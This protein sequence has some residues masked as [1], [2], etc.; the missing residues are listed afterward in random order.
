MAS[1]DHEPA[2][3]LVTGV[4]G[5]SGVGVMRAVMGPGVRIIAGDLDAY[6]AGLYLVPEPQRRLLYR[7]DDP[8]FVDHILEICKADGVDVVVPTVDSELVPLARAR[9]GFDELGVRLVLAHLETLETCLDKWT[10]VRRVGDVVRVPATTLADGDAA[11]EEIPLPVIV[12]PRSGSGSRGIRLIRERDELLRVERDGSQ[13]VQEYLPGAEFSVDV[14]TAFD[15]RVVGVVPRERLKI[16]SGIA[17]T[18]RAVH[19]GGLESSAAAVAEAIGLVGVANVQLKRADDGEPALLEVNPR[20]PGTMPL[21]IA[22]GVNMPKL[23]VGEA[24]G[25][26]MPAG[27]VQFRETAMVRYLEDQCFPVEELERAERA[28]VG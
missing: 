22:A 7:G 23:A 26:P 12:K 21:T 11:L 25:T 2:T 10:L 19:D 4:G 8:A 18:A 13:L 5:P 6:A 27:R 20:F 15:G 16:D 17:V 14:L 24:L 28:R 3:V 1:A 9:G